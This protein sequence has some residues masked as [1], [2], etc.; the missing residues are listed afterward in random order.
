VADFGI[1]RLLSEDTITT[2]GELFGTAA[3]LSPE[4]ALGRSSTAASDRY[5]LAVAAFEL[6]VGERPFTA[7]H[8]AAQARQHVEEPPPPASEH[9][10]GLPPSVDRVLARGMA[11][12]PDERYATAGAFVQ[13]LKSALGDSVRA[14]RRIPAAAVSSRAPQGPPFPLL[15]PVRNPRSRGRVLALAALALAILGIGAIATLSQGGESPVSARHLAGRPA[16]HR[17]STRAAKRNPARNASPAVPALSTSTAAPATPAPPAQ[18]TSA[19]D[20]E[21][22]G[23]QLLQSGSYSQAIST[24]RQAVAAAT[25]GSLLQG[26]AL[27]DLGRSLLLSGDPAAAVAVLEQRLQINDQ[28]PVVRKLLN[29]A[30][31]ASGQAKS[32]PPGQGSPAAGAG[33]AGLSGHGGDHHGDG[34]DNGG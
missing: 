11:K 27:Y 33:A 2:S 30:L 5:S 10:D 25:P 6:L 7:E 14:T 15:T 9:G 32:S 20:L 19:S 8:F 24:L 17:A 12:Q 34:G 21:T 1:A 13:E 23:H 26:Y 29:A 28:I 3:Y 18:P 31:A 22:H 16:A 4:Q